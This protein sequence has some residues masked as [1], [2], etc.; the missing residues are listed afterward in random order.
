MSQE[1]LNCSSHVACLS[2][3][4]KILPMLITF[5]FLFYHFIIL[6]PVPITIQVSITNKHAVCIAT[7]KPN[8]F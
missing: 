7:M 2:L 6:L 4:H 3:W 5:V 8:N 1:I